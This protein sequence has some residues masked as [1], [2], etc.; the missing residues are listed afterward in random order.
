MCR[1]FQRIFSRAV[2]PIVLILAAL[3]TG[4]HAKDIWVYEFGAWHVEQQPSIYD[5]GAYHNWK[6]A[7]I[8][9]SGAWQPFYSTITVSASTASGSGS[10]A[11]SSGSVSTSSG[12]GTTTGGTPIGSPTFSWAYVSGDIGISVN[13][14]TL[15]NPT[16]SKTITGVSLQ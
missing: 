4:A 6:D 15:Q 11:S 7:W 5:S 10:G 8:Y 13:N 9:E 3:T 1:L 2:I 12:P 16:W 14:S